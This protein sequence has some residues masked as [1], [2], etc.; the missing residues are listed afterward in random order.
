MASNRENIILLKFVF[1]RRTVLFKKRYG[2]R[3][4]C[5][6]TSVHPNLTQRINGV[7]HA[8]IRYVV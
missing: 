2:L 3:L 7:R 6:S 1:S 8:Q 5:V 4:K